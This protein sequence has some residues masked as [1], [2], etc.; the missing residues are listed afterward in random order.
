MTGIGDGAQV[1]FVPK[2]MVEIQHLRATITEEQPQE[3]ASLV[4]DT[5][6]RIESGFFLP[7][8]GI[9]FPQNPCGNLSLHCRLP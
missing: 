9:R 3:F 7:H 5:T 8:S 1:V 4:E 2:R 6:R